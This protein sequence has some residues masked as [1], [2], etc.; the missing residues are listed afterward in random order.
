VSSPASNDH[1]ELTEEEEEGSRTA[2][3]LAVRDPGDGS[4]PFTDNGTLPC[5][6]DQVP[7]GP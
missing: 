5:D 1:D 4:T 3:I 6:P 7:L 2:R